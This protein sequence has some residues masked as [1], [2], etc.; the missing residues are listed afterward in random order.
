MTRLP[1]GRYS[2]RSS[3]IR[4]ARAAC[5]KALNSPIFQAYEGH[6]F[7]IMEDTSAEIAPNQFVFFTFR[8][9]L[10]GPAAEAATNPALATG[11]SA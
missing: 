10:V 11:F 3:A 8:F 7:E 2:S 1:K 5:R 6:D 4:A 9:R